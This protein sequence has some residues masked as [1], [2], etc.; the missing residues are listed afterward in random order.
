[1]Q[2]QRSMYTAYL[3]IVNVYVNLL[4]LYSISTC[5]TDIYTYQASI[6]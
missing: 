2:I 1:M 5:S 4:N 3:D 6:N